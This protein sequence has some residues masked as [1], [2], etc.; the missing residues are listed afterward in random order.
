MINP[1]GNCHAAVDTLIR[2]QR[3]IGKHFYITN[4]KSNIDKIK[5]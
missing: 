3:W 5:L 4:T 2:T 1:V